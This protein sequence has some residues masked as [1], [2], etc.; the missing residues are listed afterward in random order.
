[1][2]DNFF[3]VLLVLVLLINPIGLAPVFLSLTAGAPDHYKQRMAIKGSF[4]AWTILLF[5]AF[6]GTP[7]LQALGITLAAFKVGG[8]LLLG[9]TGFRMVLEQ[10]QQ[11]NKLKAEEHNQDELYDVSVFPIAT[12]FIAGPG[13]ITAVMLMMNEYGNDWL[14]KLIIIIAL[15]LIIL[16]TSIILVFSAKISKY[17]PETI[18][19]VIG[20]VIGMLIIALSVQFVFNGITTT[21]LQ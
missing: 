16:V 5:F 9:V 20:R 19:S 18:T 12:L 8:G 11:R 7:I 4:I 6:A 10:R 17:I 3:S 2:L 1:M 13:A 15:T 14:G 21:F